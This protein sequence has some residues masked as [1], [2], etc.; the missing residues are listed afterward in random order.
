MER[1]VEIG[2]TETGRY[3]AFILKTGEVVEATTM[4]LLLLKLDKRLGT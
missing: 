3:R 4:H 2:R 1:L